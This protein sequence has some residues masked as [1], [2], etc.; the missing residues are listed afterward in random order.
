MARSDNVN[1]WL[2]LAANVGV[3][4]GLL[5]LVAELNQNRAVLRAQIHQSRADSFVSTRVALGDSEFLLPALTKLRAAGGLDDP[6]EGLKALDE[7]ERERVRTFFQAGYA[8]FDN[9][10]YQYRLGYLDE[11]FYRSR[12][13]RTIRAVTPIWIELGITNQGTPEFQAEVQRIYSEE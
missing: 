5:L 10:Y 11:N 9:Q 2:T 8:D 3:L 13:V 6:A 1:K 7:I 4:I 12:V